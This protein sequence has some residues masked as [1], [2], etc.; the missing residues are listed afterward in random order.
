M[1]YN[2]LLAAADAATTLPGVEEG[3]TTWLSTA[4]GFNGTSDRS[5][6][7]SGSFNWRGEWTMSAWV[8]LNSFPTF[9]NARGAFKTGNVFNDAVGIEVYSGNLHVYLGGGSHGV[10]A[11]R[12]IPMTLFPLQEWRLLTVTRAASGLMRV[13]SGATQVTSITLT[14]LSAL[15]HNDVYVGGYPGSNAWWEG[16]MAQAGV[17]LTPLTSTD[18]P[19][20]VSGPEPT[21]S[22][23]AYCAASGA[24]SVGTWDAKSNGLLTYEVVAATA[25]GDVVDSA[26]G[27]S[28]VLDLSSVPGQAVYLLVRTSNSGGYDDGDHA[29]RVSSYGS[30]DDGY[31]ELATA[32]AADARIHSGPRRPLARS[33]WRPIYR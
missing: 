18:V 4:K 16:R 20:I 29:T 21:Y 25:A 31:Y 7:R 12:N 28:G 26:T 23:G 10:N 13:Y 3:P 1:S 2:S 33:L 30:A 17:W 24:Y 32:T 11:I 15:N 22:S 8:W 14:D 5:L 6:V 27:A 9:P 19:E